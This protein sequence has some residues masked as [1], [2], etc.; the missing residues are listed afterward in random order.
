MN[1]HLNL[2]GLE[3]PTPVCLASFEDEH[4]D[5]ISDWR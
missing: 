5:Y 1:V 2:E 3:C 4:V